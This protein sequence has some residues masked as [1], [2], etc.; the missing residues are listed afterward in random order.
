MKEGEETGLCLTENEMALW[1]QEA[2]V[3]LM[4]L[5]LL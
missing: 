4:Y 1:L 2:G 5:Y 3:S